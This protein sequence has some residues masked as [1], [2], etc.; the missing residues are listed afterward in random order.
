MKNK[1]F[2]VEFPRNLWYYFDT[3]ITK[4][5]RYKQG[6]LTYLRMFC[7]K[8]QCIQLY[9]R[10][11]CRV[12][13]IRLPRNIKPPKSRAAEGCPGLSLYGIFNRKFA[14]SV[15][16]LRILT[17]RVKT[18]HKKRWKGWQTRKISLLYMCRQRKSRCLSTL[19]FL[20]NPFRE[21]AAGTDF[22]LFTSA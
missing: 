13:I 6:T 20:M 3:E 7:A 12:G 15:D 19:H 14:D 10:W 8:F 22:Y 4:C 2:S 9:S 21:E 1:K 16:E 17:N 18:L 5:L 11:F